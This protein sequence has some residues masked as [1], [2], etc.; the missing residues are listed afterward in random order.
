MDGLA[1]V[2]KMRSKVT[3]H[4]DIEYGQKGGSIRN[5]SRRVLSSICSQYKHV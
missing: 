5:G 1:I 3:G 4:D 2:G